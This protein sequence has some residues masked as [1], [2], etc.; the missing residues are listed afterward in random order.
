M[1][2]QS[3]AFAPTTRTIRYGRTYD[4]TFHTSSIEE[5][6]ALSKAMTLSGSYTHVKTPNRESFTGDIALWN[7]HEIELVRLDHGVIKPDRIYLVFGYESD[8]H[9][10]TR[11]QHMLLYYPLDPVLVAKDVDGAKRP[12][13]NA[14]NTAWLFYHTNEGTHHDYELILRGALSGAFNPLFVQY[15]SDKI[16]LEARGASTEGVTQK[17]VM[18]ASFYGLALAEATTYGAGGVSRRAGAIGASA[19]GMD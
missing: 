13:P 8:E 12:E 19:R 6:R 1:T 14:D 3:F 4:L 2:E 16:A 10:H 5:S 7:G 17:H 9:R 18:L 15:E 11:E